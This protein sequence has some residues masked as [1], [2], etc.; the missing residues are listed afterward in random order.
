LPAQTR[1]ALARAFR[2]PIV[3]AYGMTEASHQITSTP[4][5]APPA[6]AGSVGVP[7]GTS[8]AIIETNDANDASDAQVAAGH[9]GEIAVRGPGL[10]AGY[11]GSPKATARAF[12][13]GWFRTGDLGRVD[14]SGYLFI[15][16]RVKEIINRGGEKI[17]PFEVE[18]VLRDHPA[19]AEVAAFAIPDDRLGEAVGAAVVLKPEAQVDDREAIVLRRGRNDRRCSRPVECT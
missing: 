15:T 6:K 3:E 12:V 16:G 17:S 10:T 14:E 18:E 1:L 8:I 19:I 9:T 5:D 13:D 7:T 2:V 11:R 4:L